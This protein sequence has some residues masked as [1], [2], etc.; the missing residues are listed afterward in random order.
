MLL[1]KQRD[2]G[3]KYPCVNATLNTQAEPVLVSELPFDPFPSL[4]G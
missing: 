4:A 2:Y 3:A 1:I